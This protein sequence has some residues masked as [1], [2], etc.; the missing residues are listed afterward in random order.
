MVFFFPIGFTAYLNY[1]D[2]DLSLEKLV[3]PVGMAMFCLSELWEE[4][5]SWS[6][7]Y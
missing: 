1:L 5:I 7:L 6:I 4:F 2:L 3:F